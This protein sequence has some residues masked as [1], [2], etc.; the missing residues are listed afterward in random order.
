MKDN[1]II[2]WEAPAKRMN[3]KKQILY[4][5]GTIVNSLI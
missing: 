2:N 3:A 4:L 5:V 1:L